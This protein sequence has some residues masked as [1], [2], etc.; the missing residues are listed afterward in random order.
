MI[1]SVFQYPS[2]VLVIGILKMSDSR[3]QQQLLALH[4][5]QLET[6]KA[7]LKLQMLQEEAGGVPGGDVFT[8]LGE[9]GKT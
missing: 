8:L 3:R 4:L 9:N 2:S 7:Q 1:S 5:L 6:D